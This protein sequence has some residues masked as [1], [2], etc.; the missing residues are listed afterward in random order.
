MPAQQ[1]GFQQAQYGVQ[2]QQRLLVPP[3]TIIKL[4]MSSSPGRQPPPASTLSRQAA[5]LNNPYEFTVDDVVKF[6][7]SSSMSSDRVLT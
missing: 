2:Q 4:N 7:K 5:A 3:K 1:Q 6:G